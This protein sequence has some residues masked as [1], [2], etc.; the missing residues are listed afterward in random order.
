MKTQQ[1]IRDEVMSVLTAIAP[2]VEPDE[3]RDDALL[4]DQ[5]DLDS[6]DWLRFLVGIHERLEVDI[7]EADYRKLCTLADVVR[8]VQEHAAS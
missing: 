6:M 3:L 8:Y 7:P 4:R 2:E 1:G 5:V